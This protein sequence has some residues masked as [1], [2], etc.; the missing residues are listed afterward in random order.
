MEN[1]TGIGPTRHSLLIAIVTFGLCIF[2]LVPTVLGG[3][4]FEMSDLFAVP[5]ACGL[6]REAEEALR[7]VKLGN[8]ATNIMVFNASRDGL[9]FYWK[10][11]LVYPI[12]RVT[13]YQMLNIPPN[14]AVDIW[15]AGI[16]D[17]LTS[18][19]Y[20]NV[21]FAKG[22]V[23]IEVPATWPVDVTAIYTAS[24]GQQDGV[25]SIDTE[26]FYPMWYYE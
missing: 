10:V 5:Y 20:G 18:V 4:H 6:M 1:Q 11:V 21:E 16:R 9:D 24:P 2:I 7:V 8:Y 25:T 19:N 23:V 17:M 22:Y 14:Q 26:T 3:E 12:Q 13:T 15:C